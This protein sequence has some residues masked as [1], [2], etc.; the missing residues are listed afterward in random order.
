[1]NIDLHTHSMYSS[2]SGLRPETLIKI[3]RKKHL[4]GIAV[5]DHNT[6]KG[7]IR[8]RSIA[9]DDFLV[10]PGTEIRTEKGEIIGLFVEE[11]ITAGIFEEVRE[12]IVD[13]GGIVVLPHPYRNNSR[14]PAD[15][16]NTV[17][18]L[19]VMNARTSPSLNEKALLLAEKFQ[20]PKVGGSDAHTI[21]EIGRAYTYIPGD[22]LLDRND[23]L[24]ANVSIGGFET[25]RSVRVLSAGFGKMIRKTRKIFNR[26]RM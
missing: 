13:Q 20:K 26:D 23:I 21:F 3:A 5:T 9:P 12:R 1:M 11:E 10:I 25:P 24:K 8:T 4:D 22:E 2:D 7:G 6:I 17:D 19:E 14:D 16:V 15:L 18:A